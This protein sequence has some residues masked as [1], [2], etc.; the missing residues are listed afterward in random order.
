MYFILGN[1]TI[2]KEMNH[3]ACYRLQNTRHTSSYSCLN[4]QTN[5]RAVELYGLLVTFELAAV[6]LTRG[7]ESVTKPKQVGGKVRG[8]GGRGGEHPLH[9]VAFG[10]SAQCHHLLRTVNPTPRNAL[11]VRPFVTFFTPS[12]AQ[13]HQSNL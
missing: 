13:A 9:A 3:V 10:Q 11:S 5:R 8:V 7:L 4:Q 2:V 1:L 12:N 6:T